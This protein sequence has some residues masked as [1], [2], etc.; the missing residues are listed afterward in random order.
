MSARRKKFFKSHENFIFNCL[1]I[2]TEFQHSSPQK[3][4]DFATSKNSLLEGI[5]G[6]SIKKCNTLQYYKMARYITMG[7]QVKHH[8]R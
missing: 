8:P 2:V 3:V 6:I 1:Q 5:K 4:F 7:M